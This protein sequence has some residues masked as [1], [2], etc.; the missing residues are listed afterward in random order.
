MFI[1]GSSGNNW[2]TLSGPVPL[3]HPETHIFPSFVQFWRQI[4]ST[5]NKEAKVSTK[6]PMHLSKEHTPEPKWEICCD[7]MQCFPLFLLLL[8]PNLPLNSIQEK[9]KGLGHQNHAGNVLRHK[10]FQ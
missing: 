2:R 1:K 7:T 4:G 6:A 3:Y 9:L 8:L 5:A 10:Q